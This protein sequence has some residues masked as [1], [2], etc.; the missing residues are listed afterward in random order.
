[1]TINGKERESWKAEKASVEDGK[2]LYYI[3]EA[4]AG[5]TTTPRPTI[6][7]RAIETSLRSGGP[8]QVG[9][10]SHGSGPD[11]QDL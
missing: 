5:R 2:G 8:S 9:A 7:S 3:M 6:P 11:N 4:D 1:M 10:R